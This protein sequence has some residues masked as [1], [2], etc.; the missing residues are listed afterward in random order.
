MHPP[1]AAIVMYFCLHN[2]MSHTCIKNSTHAWPACTY[3]LPEARGNHRTM[4]KASERANLSL[5]MHCSLC[6]QGWRYAISMSVLI[7]LRLTQITSC[8]AASAARGKV[9]PL[10]L[11]ASNTTTRFSSRWSNF[12]SFTARIHQKR[13]QIRNPK[14]SWGACPHIPLAG[15]LCALKSHTGTPFFKILDPPLHAIH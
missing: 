1:L 12:C 15:A 8:F 14:F 9:T 4:S 7:F 5:F 6:S 10:I 3:I 11:R 13:S 2:C